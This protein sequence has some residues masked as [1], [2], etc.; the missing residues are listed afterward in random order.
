MDDL[1][2]RLS[3]LDTRAQRLKSWGWRFIFIIY[4]CFGY[5]AYQWFSDPEV[6]YTLPIDVPNNVLKHIPERF[7]KDYRTVSSLWNTSTLPLTRSE[8]LEAV[9]DHKYKPVGKALDYLE[10]ENVPGVAY[11]MAQLALA[12]DEEL[13]KEYWKIV[14]KDAHQVLVKE[15][16]KANDPNIQ[17]YFYILETN[18][19][20]GPVSETAQKGRLHQLPVDMNALREAHHQRGTTIMKWSIVAA[21]LNWLVSFL[22][23]MILRKRLKRLNALI[24]HAN[25]RIGQQSKHGVGSNTCQELKVD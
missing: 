24:T 2:K 5:G 6:P 22:P 21:L 15:P 9:N 8:F 17:S 16:E 18:A 4:S 3:Q 20:G 13:S 7:D 1:G 23:A 14:S 12:N 25:A 11:L 19:H 10:L